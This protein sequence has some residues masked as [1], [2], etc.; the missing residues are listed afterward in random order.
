MIERIYIPTV[1]RTDK[2]ITFENLP[3]ELK[4]K[5]IMVVEPSERPLYKYN[6]DYLVLPEKIVGTWTQLATTRYLIH[7]HAG[8]IRYVVADDDVII[9]RRN[10]KYW[11][12]VSNMER[13]KRNATPEEILEMF[14]TFDSWLNERNIG[15]VGPSNSEA[16]PPSTE[17]SD[18]K[19]VFTFVTIDG[20]MLSQ[21]IDSM[22]ITSIRVAEDVLFIFECL[23]RGI[24]TR[25]STEWIMDNRSL[26]TQ[27]LKNTRA[28]WEEM[29]GA[30]NQPEDHFQTDEHYKALAYIQSKFPHAMKIY[31]KDGRRKNTKYWKKAYAGR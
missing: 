23:A 12:G 6:C 22:D 20:A 1:R 8:S 25:L 18:T 13:S 3:D 24:N 15:I 21:V 5:V 17:Y 19:G 30:D 28:V 10:A 7:K 14:S 9:K 31:E 2:Q 26:N 29:Y 16:P 11:T 27:E 4:S